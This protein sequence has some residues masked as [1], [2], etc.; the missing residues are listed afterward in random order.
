MLLMATS[1]I[2]F[3]ILMPLATFLHELG[4]AALPLLMDK[5]VKIVMGNANFVWRFSLRNLE[6]K[7]SIFPFYKGH[8][9]WENVD[10]IWL[11]V[12]ILS[13]GPLTSLASA[14]ALYWLMNHGPSSEIF[15]YGIRFCFWFCLIQFFMTAI[16]W[17]YP[18]FF[19]G[20]TAQSSDGYQIFRLLHGA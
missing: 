10:S 20:Y 15:D 8:C 4:H 9:Y 7:S 1:F 2:G 3:F 14:V 6:V 17:Q 18:S 19:P 16:P 13:A 5:P 12:M 11:Q